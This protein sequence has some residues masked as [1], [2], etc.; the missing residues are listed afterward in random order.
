MTQPT[1]TASPNP[2]TLAVTNPVLLTYLNTNIARLATSISVPDTAYFT[3]GFLPAPAGLPSTSVVNFM[4]FVNGQYIEPLAIISFTESSG[5]C[6]LV[7]D[8]GQLGF[9][10]IPADEVVAIGKFI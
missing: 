8:P 4:F 6:T 5:I 2:N 3:A 9:T 7:L 1:T 10:L